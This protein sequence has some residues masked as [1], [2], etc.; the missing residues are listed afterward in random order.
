MTARLWD[1]SRSSENK[2]AVFKGHGHVRSVKCIQF[3]PDF[4][5]EFATGSRENSIYLWDVRE[6]SKVLMN[7]DI[8]YFFSFI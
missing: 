1:V 7:L 3:K 4:P 6:P 8:S 5:H 2:I